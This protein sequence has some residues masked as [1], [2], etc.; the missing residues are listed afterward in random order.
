MT[1]VTSQRR[2]SAL[3][4]RPRAFLH[5]CQRLT[6]A[7]VAAPQR[8]YLLLSLGFGLAF[9][10]AT[11]PFVAPDEGAH[12]YRAFHVS[13]GHLVP[14]RVQDT[15]GGR[16]PSSFKDCVAYIH[17]I[18]WRPES[19][20]ARGDVAGMFSVALAPQHREL[21]TF[22]QGCS[23]G[24]AAYAP[25]AIAIALG[26][27]CDDRPAML[28]YWGRLGNL[29]FG[30]CLI[31]LAIRIAPVFKH[32]LMLT[33]LLPMASSQLASV[34]H[35]PVAIGCSF[36]LAGLVLRSLAN[37]QL[38]VSG[39]EQ[40]G[41][42]LASLA[43]AL[44]KTC[45]FPLTLLTLLI[46]RSRFASLKHFAVFQGVTLVLSLALSYGWKAEAEHFFPDARTD[47][48]A[49]CSIA[50]QK[51]HILA[52]PLAF[53][54]VLAR[55]VGHHKAFWLSS[56][57]GNL[58]FLDTPIPRHWVALYLM[59]LA[60]TALVDNDPRFRLTWRPR[61]GICCAAT[62]TIGLMFL[63]LYLWWTPVDW[64]V[65]EGIQGRYFLPCAPWL[66]LVG[67]SGFVHTTLSHH[68]RNAL[69]SAFC[70]CGL[71]AAVTTVLD[72]FYAERE[73]PL[74]VVRNMFGM[75]NSTGSWAG[76]A[77]AE[78]GATLPVISGDWDGDGIESLGAYDSR[79]A[80]FGLCDDNGGQ[81]LQFHFGPAGAELTPL[82]GDWNGDG[83]D[84]VGL[85]DPATGALLLRNQHAGGYADITALY[86]ASRARRVPLVGDFDGRGKD[87]V[88]VYEPE[89]GRFL[90]A[91]V[92]P[93]NALG[94]RR[95]IRFGP[96]AS[97]CLPFAGDW[98][99]DGR[100]TVA[101]YD[102]VASR[103]HFADADGGLTAVR[104]V[105][106]LSASQSLLA[107][108]ADGSGRDALVACDLADPERYVSRDALLK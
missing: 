30:T 52:D 34:S 79:T 96:K 57:V 39:C 53:A 37:P 86:G 74:L 44:C 27:L 61:I 100:D 65:V 13:E 93:P 60:F 69:L 12:F 76:E 59:A 38:A 40:A 35:D 17:H 5:L 62:A 94:P 75:S 98:D 22:M 81:K 42:A 24:P 3:R 43:L 54:A 92:L 31:Y 73:V 15:G 89:Q 28:L 95:T 82:A 87:S 29:V 91:E 56:F 48:D 10:I 64:P 26:R 90:L 1:E 72:R 85:F 21:Q 63:A 46:P 6:L 108:D 106:R 14:D 49:P 84:T 16:L 70:C 78:T 55:S 9:L 23:S 105:E 66:A 47:S 19:K 97:H 11:P 107:I 8:L 50:Q 45:Y 103:V 77:V 20:L 4:E 58:G 25:A 104:E 18:P 101:V 51:A 33:A 71:V 41:T 83:V 80:Q 36:L 7:S 102:P 32:V 88:A 99:G 2:S 67:Y 68:A